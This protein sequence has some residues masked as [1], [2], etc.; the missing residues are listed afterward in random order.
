MSLINDALKKAQRQRAAEA[1]Q[2]ATPPPGMVPPSPAAPSADPPASGGPAPLSPEFAPPRPQKRRAPI[3]TQTLV[4]IAVGCV[5]LLLAGAGFAAFF[6]STKDAPSDHT[7]RLAQST[8]APRPPP[9]TPA[10]P[11]APAATPV[12][13]EVAVTTSPVPS[14]P[15][16]PAPDSPSPPPAAPSPPGVVPSATPPEPTPAAPSAP[17]TPAVIAP[18]DSTP[19]PPAE[20]VAPRPDPAIHAFLD[21]LRVT[22]IRASATDPKVL[23]NDRVFRRNDIVHPVLRLR[24]TGITTSTLTFT[25]PNGFE[26]EKNF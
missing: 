2:G 18:A 21:T 8:P 17:A 10:A 14:T 16:T 7:P 11:P 9:A 13:P 5:V 3:P 6:L 22:G 25:D 19:P 23:M 26:Y 24:L 1:L 20:P 12:Q 15:A 4:L